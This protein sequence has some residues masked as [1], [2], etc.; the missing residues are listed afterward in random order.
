MHIS[1]QNA[2]LVEFLEQPLGFLKR[3]DQRLVVQR[4]IFGHQGFV[5][6]HFEPQGMGAVFGQPGF[7]PSHG[8]N[9]LFAPV[10]CESASDLIVEQEKR[11]AAD[12]TAVGVAQV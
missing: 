5:I 4:D 12:I 7:W 2:A 9:I 1:I 11:G 3:D 10:T 6:V 8:E